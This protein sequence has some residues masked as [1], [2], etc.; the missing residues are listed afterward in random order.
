MKRLL[1]TFVILIS[2]LG[3]AGAVWADEK[4]DYRKAYDAYQAGD[5]AQAV[6]W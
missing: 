6:K 5:Y 1:T 3:G 2:F 4:A